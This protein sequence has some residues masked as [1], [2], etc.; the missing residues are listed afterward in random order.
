MS[1]TSHATTNWQKRDATTNPAMSGLYK[2]VVLS[3]AKC[4]KRTSSAVVLVV[5]AKR[6]QNVMPRQKKSV[7][8][9][10]RNPAQGQKPFV[11]LA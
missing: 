8:T 4:L 9:R 5:G 10:T 3:L 1:T 7:P 11:G 6:R 2:V